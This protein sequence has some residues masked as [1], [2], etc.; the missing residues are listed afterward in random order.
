MF[1]NY[2]CDM[3]IFLVEVSDPEKFTGCVLHK[4]LVL[5]I[6]NSVFIESR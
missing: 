5:V 3:R 6:T 2:Y 1:K 4:N